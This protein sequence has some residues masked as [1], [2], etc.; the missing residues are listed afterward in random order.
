MISLSVVFSYCMGTLLFRMPQ[1][2]KHL[3][4]CGSGLRAFFS[5]ADALGICGGGS[6][7]LIIAVFIINTVGKVARQVLLTD[8]MP[9]IV[10]RIYISPVKRRA[11]V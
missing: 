2:I 9:G 8:I 7:G 10:V 6:L 3:P 4:Q 5:A 11:Q 1:R